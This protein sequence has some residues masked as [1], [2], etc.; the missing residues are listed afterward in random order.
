MLVTVVSSLLFG[1]RHRRQYFVQYHSYSLACST[2]IQNLNIFIRGPR[3]RISSMILHHWRLRQG[4]VPGNKSLNP[5]PAD[6]RCLLDASYET[7]ANDRVAQGSHNTHGAYDGR[8][9]S[10]EQRIWIKAICIVYRFSSDGSTGT[11]YHIRSFP[12]PISLRYSEG[13]ASFI[14]AR[15]AVRVRVRVPIL[16]VSSVCDRRTRRSEPRP[17]A[18]T[19]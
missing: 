14:G 9:I 17:C 2:Q 4:S 13:I 8:K 12:S 7:G 19:A 6:K 11:D 16:V 15:S 10:S 5:F 3:A 1:S 18:V